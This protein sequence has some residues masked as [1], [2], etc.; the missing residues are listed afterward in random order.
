MGDREVGSTFTQRGLE[1][2]G[3]RSYSADVGVRSMF[4]Q[5]KWDFQGTEVH[6]YKGIQGL[7]VPSYKSDSRILSSKAEIEG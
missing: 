7:G 5:R 3:V 4:T 1:G 6:P 2:L